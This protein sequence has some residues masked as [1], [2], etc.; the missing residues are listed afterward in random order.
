MLDSI[1][2]RVADL[3]E[4]LSQLDGL[5]ET[6]D[7]GQLPGLTLARTA[8][9]VDQ[10]TSRLGELVEKLAAGGTEPVAETARRRKRV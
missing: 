3:V 9:A 5:L 1:R 7:P 2:G 8:I 10:A 6:G 4:T